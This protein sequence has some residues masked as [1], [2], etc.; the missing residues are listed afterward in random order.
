MVKR[1]I[2]WTKKAQTE[3]KDILEYWIIRN[4]SKTFSIKLNKLI[5][6]TLQLLTE[7]P[8]IGRKTDYGDVRVKIVRNYLIF[9]EFSDSELVVL[10]I[11]DCR[12]DEQ[13]F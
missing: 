4:R 10:S 13:T 1:K 12:K 5:I 2:I 11:W 7:N 3:R 9:Y 8:K 6:S